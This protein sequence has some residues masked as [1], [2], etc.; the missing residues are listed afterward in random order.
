MPAEHRELNS[1]RV[2]DVIAST[3]RIKVSAVRASCQGR[4]S[5]RI[6]MTVATNKLSAHLSRPLTLPPA[7]IGFICRGMRRIRYSQ[8]R[9]SRSSAEFL[10]AAWPELSVT[11]LVS[12]ERQ[13]FEPEEPR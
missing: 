1:P 5:K 12:K 10:S 13:R 3:E 11:L 9:L 6:R 7:D 2:C 8:S 4:V